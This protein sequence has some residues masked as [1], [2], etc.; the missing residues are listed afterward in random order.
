MDA[1]LYQAAEKIFFHPHCLHGNPVDRRRPA[2]VESF[3]KREDAPARCVGL[4]DKMS[5]SIDGELRA[6]CRRLSLLIE[7]SQ[8]RL[9][10][11]HRMS[12]A[13]LREHP[14]SPCQAQGHLAVERMPR[15]WEECDVTGREP[16]TSHHE[17]IAVVRPARRRGGVRPS[18]IVGRR[19]YGLRQLFNRPRRFAID[20][21]DAPRGEIRR[22][23][24]ARVRRSPIVSGAGP[25][26]PTALPPRQSR[27]PGPQPTRR[28]T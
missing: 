21:P 7:Q 27:R 20:E 26:Q 6:S 25:D 11:F 15:R 5:R 16:V 23:D 17:E 10:A 3:G 2:I 19:R 9:P 22:G 28:Q 12:H 13:I 14:S 4:C 18:G 24:H 8:P 1:A